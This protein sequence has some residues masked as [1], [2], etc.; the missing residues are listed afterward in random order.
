MLHYNLLQTIRAPTLS[1]TPLH[2]VNIDTPTESGQLQ[3]EQLRRHT[4]TSGNLL[5]YAQLQHLYL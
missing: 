5:T 1:L 4:L 2:K 3:A